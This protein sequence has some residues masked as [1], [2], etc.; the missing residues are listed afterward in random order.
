MSK[1]SLSSTYYAFNKR[2][3]TQLGS[4]KLN[5]PLK[6]EKKIELKILKFLPALNFKHDA[7]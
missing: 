6:L 3:I 7:F 2:F 4:I 5:F 1:W